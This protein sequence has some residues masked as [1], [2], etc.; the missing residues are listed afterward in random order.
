MADPNTTTLLPTTMLFT[1]TIRCN[2]WCY[3]VNPRDR[4]G[5][6]LRNQGSAAILSTQITLKDDKLLANFLQK[7]SNRCQE[8]AMANSVM[9]IPVNGKHLNL[10]TQYGQI[11]LDDIA[12]ACTAREERCD[13][14]TIPAIK[15]TKAHQEVLRDNVLFK[16]ITASITEKAL[17]T[18]PKVPKEK[19]FL[20]H[21]GSYL[22]GRVLKASKIV[23]EDRNANLNK[24]LAL[25]DR[26]PL[27]QIARTTHSNPPLF[28]KY[29][30]EQVDTLTSF[31]TEKQLL[32]PNLL[33]AYEAMPGGTEWSQYLISI[34]NDIA[35][36][37]REEPDVHEL[38][39]ET[40]LMFDSYDSR[41]C[42]GTGVTKD[43]P[44]VRLA[45]QGQRRNNNKNNNNKNNNNNGSNNNNNSN[46]N[47]NNNNSNN[48]TGTKQA[49]QRERR[50]YEPWKFVPSTTG[51]TKITMN[52]RGR[53]KNESHEYVWCPNH[54]ENGMWCRSPHSDCKGRPRTQQTTSNN[55][56]RNNNNTGT[57]T[58]KSTSMAATKFAEAINDNNN[59]DNN[60]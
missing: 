58:N 13:D 17:L 3:E 6:E 12:A 39:R 50:P 18:L 31:D 22:L 32:V 8:L 27:L 48:N 45:L 57:T 15:R 53:K 7:C 38:I 56:R 34:R 44:A 55:T 30:E 36:K 2:P 42:W 46:N 14:L 5:I 43:D 33:S 40:N 24:I 35:Q 29:V 52:N 51:Q 41:K 11:S 26:E 4:I 23:I 54:A 25:L 60:N 20:E 21:S 28:N 19:P 10:L 47:Q 37:K 59:N 1:S 16:A 9:S 49:P